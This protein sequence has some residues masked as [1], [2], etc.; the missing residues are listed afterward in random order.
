MNAGYAR[1]STREQNLNGQ[2][3]E[4]TAAGC[5]EVF[6]EKASN[7]PCGRGVCPCVFE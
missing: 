2:V 4:L 7:R 6:R 1:V 3:A 5:A